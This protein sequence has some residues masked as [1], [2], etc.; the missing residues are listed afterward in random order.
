MTRALGSQKVPGAKLDTGIAEPPQP[1][2]AGFLPVSDLLSCFH[3]AHPATP[4]PSG[5]GGP[6]QTPAGLPG[7]HPLLP[8]C[9]LFLT[10]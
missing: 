2:S 7:P 10:L 4:D 6:V 5:A 9:P 1:G 3:R 8:V